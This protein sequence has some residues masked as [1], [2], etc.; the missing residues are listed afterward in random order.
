MPGAEPSSA[1]GPARV[2]GEGAEEKEEAAA[3]LAGPKMR[4]PT[5]ATLPPSTPSPASSPAATPP[6]HPHPHPRRTTPQ[7]AAASAAAARRT[8]VR[9]PRQRPRP[10]PDP[11]R[12][13][14]HSHSQP[15][16]M[17]DRL[18]AGL[19]RNRAAVRLAE[20]VMARLLLLRAPRGGGGPGGGGIL[21][22]LAGTE[23][24]YALLNLWGVGTD[25]LLDGPG[26]G[27]GMTVGL[28]EDLAA[29][30][31]EEDDDDLAAQEED[32]D[33]G[34]GDD[35]AGGRGAM[36]LVGA[37]GAAAAG[38]LSPLLP[39]LGVT[40]PPRL[41]GPARTAVAL[42]AV[43]AA[44]E[45]AAP[46]LEA[47]ALATSTSAAVRPELRR[48]SALVSLERVRFWCRLGLLAMHLREARRRMEEEEKEAAAGEGGPS[49][50]PVAAVLCRGGALRPGEPGIPAAPER[51]RLRRDGYVGRRTGRRTLV[52][53][54]GPSYSSSPSASASPPPP[55]P[56]TL[57]AALATPRGKLATL[58]AGELLHIARPLAWALAERAHASASHPAALARGPWDAEGHRLHR[59]GG[60]RRDRLLLLAWAVGVAMDLASHRLT[61]A[62]ASGGGG[63]GTTD[64]VPLPPPL[65][66]SLALPPS[67]VRWWAGIGPIPSPGPGLPPPTLD[68]LRR[69]K[70]R[71]MLHLLRAPVWEALTGPAAAGIAAVLGRAVPLAGGPLGRYLLDV[72]EYWRSHHFMLEG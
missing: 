18:R 32:D 67:L 51:E 63:P 70:A 71:W 68:E 11:V 41:P 19:S 36:G 56:G 39:A 12:G 44:A 40:H 64:P 61:L 29:Q 54:H 1:G 15:Q 6:Q 35:G 9:S 50:P 66:L 52:G 21:P 46:A 30:E 47:L 45:C 38:L 43:L 31:E 14:P 22:A 57:A 53:G 16:P 60:G 24:L 27:S 28:A 4:A 48:R 8:P 65:P 34:G 20:D 2:D 58:G 25:A 37:A 7:L 5:P 33:G 17:A 72:L 26:D 62:A 23:V 10:P 13:Q 42:R 59:E 69:R 3:T 55:A 49:I